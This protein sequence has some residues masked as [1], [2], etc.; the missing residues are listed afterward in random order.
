MKT[1]EQRGTLYCLLM[2]SYCFVLS[3]ARGKLET[4]SFI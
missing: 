4:V 3:S 1:I 2:D